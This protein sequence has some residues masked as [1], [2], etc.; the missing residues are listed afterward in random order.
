MIVPFSREWW[1]FVSTL[2]S[3]PFTL[4]E[5]TKGFTSS[6]LLR[7]LGY[8]GLS[9]CRDQHPCLR[10]GPNIV[11]PLYEVS[12]SC[13]LD[14]IQV[15]AEMWCAQR[16][17]LLSSNLFSSSRV[18]DFN[19]RGYDHF[20]GPFV[21]I[22]LL[23]SG[24]TFLIDLFTVGPIVDV[25]RVFKGI[26][27]CWVYSLGVIFPVLPWPN[28]TFHCAS[29]VSH[30]HSKPSHPLSYKVLTLTLTSFFLTSFLT[31]NRPETHPLFTIPSTR[32]R[33]NFI[34]IIKI[35]YLLHTLGFQS[36][37][38][39]ISRLI[40][41]KSRQTPS[42]KSPFTWIKSK[43]SIMQQL[44]SNRWDSSISTW[45][46]LNNIFFSCKSKKWNEII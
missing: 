9:I 27:G 43:W 15:L 8:A 3:S 18:P 21:N 40:P 32:P 23:H 37:L 6:Q 30:W 44:E 28:H 35:A 10:Q 31:L 38:S 26:N 11:I 25:Q 39:K 2:K 34:Q 12:S 1:A 20:H 46:S 14:L 22:C 19:L 29:S 13:H 41:L 36:I 5:D 33:L 16:A 17:T 7:D 42:S 45:V 24:P 4:G